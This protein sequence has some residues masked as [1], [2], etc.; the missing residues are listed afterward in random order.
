MRSVIVF[1][2]LFALILCAELYAGKP[3]RIVARFMLA[4]LLADLIKQALVGS[5]TFRAM[6]GFLFTAELVLLVTFVVVALKANRVWPLTVA[7]LQLLVCLAHVARLFS[8][9]STNAQIYWAMTSLPSFLICLI[10][11]GAIFVHRR[12]VRRLGPVPDW[13]SS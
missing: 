10:V 11:A 6:N 9:A 12:R 13:R 8:P 3:E 1:T 2:G 7:G 4:E 5:A